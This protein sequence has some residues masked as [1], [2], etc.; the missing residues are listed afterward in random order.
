MS[1]DLP[2]PRVDG[3][4]AFAVAAGQFVRRDDGAV[5]RLLLGSR[6]LVLLD[7]HRGPLS[8]NSAVSVRRS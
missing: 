5:L 2:E 6:T 1:V 4:V 3:G 7:R 8:P